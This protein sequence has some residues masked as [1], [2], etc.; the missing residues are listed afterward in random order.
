MTDLIMTNAVLTAISSRQKL[1]GKEHLVVPV[2]ALVEGVLNKVLYS[3][4]ELQAFSQ[5]WN[6]VPIPVNH[7]RKN[8]IHVSANS[9]EFEDT[10]NIG[11]LFNVNYSD[12]KLKGE[13]WI[14]VEKAYRLGFGD[15]ITNFDAG[16]MMEVSTGLFSDSISYSGIHNNSV[17]DLVAKNIRPDHLALLQDE[18]G[19]CS[20]ADGCGAMRTN[21]EESCCSECADE[22]SSRGLLQGFRDL[23][24]KLNG[25]SHM[26][27]DTKDI[28][29]NAGE[30]VTE[31]KLVSDII[32]NKGNKFTEDD[33]NEL[34]ALSDGILTKIAL[35]TDEPILTNNL[36][37]NDIELF[38]RLQV[39][40]DQRIVE[41]RKQVATSN[42]YLSE[43]IIANMNIET[44]EA[45]FSGITP[46]G[47]YTAKGGAGVK[48]NSEKKRT[49]VSV[50]FDDTDGDKK[51]G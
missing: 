33:R 30:T 26:G 21:N 36:T 25:T 37:D 51:D 5:A 34:V 28:N 40:E 45:M 22:N 43:A 44:L 38:R 31:N 20:I 35:H 32:V 19:A 6:G 47:D 18:K 1:D 10:T 2:I 27:K 14:D 8:G 12:K 50:L 39:K 11:R 17:Y 9:P 3:G 15:I 7:P 13:L 48:A 41:M 4:K 29:S 46:S 24:N 23:F 49:H 42:A 16:K